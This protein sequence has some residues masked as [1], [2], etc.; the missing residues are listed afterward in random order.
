MGL[1]AKSTVIN[2][3]DNTQERSFT[4]ADKLISTMFKIF[5]QKH[6]KVTVVVQ[7]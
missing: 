5:I 1:R 3:L 4:T 6:I 2:C 7:T